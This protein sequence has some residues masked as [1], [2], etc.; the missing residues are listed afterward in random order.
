MNLDEL[1]DRLDNGM[2]VYRHYMSPNIVLRKKYVSPLREEKVASFALFRNNKTQRICFTDFGGVSGDYW[3]FV[4][5]MF[6][7][8]FLD[9]KKKVE[10]DILGG[11]SSIRPPRIVKRSR[12]VYDEPDTFVEIVPTIRNYNRTDLD[13]FRKAHITKPTL[14]KYHVQPASEFTIIKG[15]K[16]YTIHEKSDSPIYVIKFSSGRM[17]IYR[18]FEKVYKWTSNLVAAKDIFGL[19]QLPEQADVIFMMAGNRDTM[20]FYEVMGIPT[21]ALSSESANLPPEMYSYLKAISDKICLLYDNDR[22]GRRK[23]SELTETYGITSFT[24]VL[25]ISAANDWTAMIEGNNVEAISK[26][27]EK[28]SDKVELIH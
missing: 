1:N 18:P 8:D 22:Q 21:I 2:D 10:E 11:G 13:W 5:L 19:D 23:S 4:K 26:T 25:D 17:K 14:Y 27:I 24:D 20:S 3:Q 6:G 7:L 16:Q 12:K 9:A 15:D 28:I